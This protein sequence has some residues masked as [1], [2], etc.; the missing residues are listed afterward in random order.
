VI[1]VPEFEPK[2]LRGGHAVHFR[3]QDPEALGMR[4][5]VMTKMR[6]VAPFPKLG[7]TYEHG[8]R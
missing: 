7:A 6:G 8:A 5:D 3:C 1:A 4:I 2:Y